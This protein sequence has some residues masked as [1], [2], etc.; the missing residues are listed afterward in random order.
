MGRKSAYVGESAKDRSINL[1]D[2]FIKRSENK[3]QI[4]KDLPIRRKDPN[5]PINLWPVKDQIEYY[6]NRSDAQKFDEL[7]SNY[8]NWIS[9]V[10]T[11]SGIYSRTFDEFITM[12]N[13]K[14][15]L[16]ELFQNKTLP[17]QAVYELRKHGVY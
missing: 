13:L 9:T 8:S 17:K 1:M 6:E 3:N 12:K 11:S 5:I 16:Q 10:K 15:Y 14:P 4:V 7:Y 2:K